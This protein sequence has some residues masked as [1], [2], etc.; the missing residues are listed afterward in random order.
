MGLPHSERFCTPPGQVRA[1]VGGRC[2]GGDQEPFYVLD[3]LGV[4]F[5]LIMPFR[6]AHLAEGGKA[7]MDPPGRFW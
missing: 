4:L 2:A 7:G 5:V 3:K 1:E 6:S